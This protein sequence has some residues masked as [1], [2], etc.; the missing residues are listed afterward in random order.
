MN[1]SALAA[2]EPKSIRSVLPQFLAGYIGDPAAADACRAA[3]EAFVAAPPDDA[4]QRLLGHV[5][6][7][8]GEQRV[9]PAD[10]LCRALARAWTRHVV[11]S[12]TVSG[13]EHLRAAAEGPAVILCNHLSYLDTI[14]MDAA[15]AWEGHA[16]LADR[17]VTVAGPKVYED[18][19]R[20]IAAA[21][22]NTLPA[23]QSTRLGHTAQLT[24]RELARQVIEAMR[25]AHDAIAQGFV[26]QLYPEGSRTRTGRLRPFLKAVYRYLDVPDLA[27]VP[28]AITGTERI[29]GIDTS[30]LEP[31]PVTVTFG[32]PLRV[33]DAGGGRPALVAAR[34]R[35]ATL[36]PATYQ[37][38]PSEPAIQ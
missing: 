9:Y 5:G 13:V 20:L 2:L 35:V 23:P 25:A 22:L 32:E 11:T 4:L 33:A 3:M 27:V 12:A 10:P 7:L 28:S 30:R 19:F 34:E 38:D 15:L 37:P 16:D 31:G 17:V 8:G 14:A 21:S 6:S 18:L 29:F 26:L 36:L 1:A 24:P